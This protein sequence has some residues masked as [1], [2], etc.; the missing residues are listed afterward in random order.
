MKQFTVLHVFS[1]PVSEVSSKLCSAHPPS[2]C[3][4]IWAKIS[5]DAQAQCAKHFSPLHEPLLLYMSLCSSC[6]Y[7]L[8]QSGIDS[9]NSLD[10]KIPSLS[11][12][13][14]WLSSTAHALCFPVVITMHIF[15]SIASFFLSFSF[16][17]HSVC[18]IRSQIAL[19]C[20]DWIEKLS[21]E[22]SSGSVPPSPT[23]CFFP[24]SYTTIIV[25]SHSHKP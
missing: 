13:F 3:P 4:H 14:L 10:P 7:N 18:L 1:L 5:Y 24:L 19:W 25:H 17:L 6:V 22:L 9:T 12:P 11:P 16:L 20:V 23:L 15:S 21:Q 8:V 2:L